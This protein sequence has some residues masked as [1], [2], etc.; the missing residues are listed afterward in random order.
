M[1]HDT[2]LALLD[3]RDGIQRKLTKARKDFR[4]GYDA[5]VRMISDGRDYGRGNALWVSK[6]YAWQEG[7]EAGWHNGKAD[8]L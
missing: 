2:I 1:A 6:S 8:G 4:N 3:E 5:G 7:Y